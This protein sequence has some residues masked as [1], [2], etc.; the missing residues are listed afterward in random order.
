MEAFRESAIVVV[1]CFP[2]AKIITFIE[3]LLRAKHFSKYF[4]NINSYSSQPPFCD[5]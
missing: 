5:R 1:D 3:N 4:I 2:N